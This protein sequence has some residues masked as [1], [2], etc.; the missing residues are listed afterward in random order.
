[1]RKELNWENITEKYLFSLFTEHHSDD[2]KC[3]KAGLTPPSTHLSRRVLLRGWVGCRTNI[4]PSTGGKR[5]V[6]S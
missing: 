4:L 6:A 1:M 3:H 5:V 2:L